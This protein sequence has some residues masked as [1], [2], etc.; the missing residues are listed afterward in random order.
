MLAGLWNDLR[1]RLRALFRR[2]AVERELESEVQ[3]HLAMKTEQLER[4]IVAERTREIGVRAALGASRGRLIGQIVR[5]GLVL[6]GI[7]ALIGLA[8]AALMSRGLTT[9]LFGVTPHDP[10]TFI[11]VIGLLGLLALLA[12]GVPAWRV[13]RI[14]PATTLR[15]E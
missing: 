9:L 12:S 8:G 13:A 1:Y 14:D 5:H 3:F 15:T 11:G 6:T 10:V 7:G 2:A 4:S